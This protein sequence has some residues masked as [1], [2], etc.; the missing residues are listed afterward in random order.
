MIHP[1]PAY[2][3]VAPSCAPLPSPPSFIPAP[4][5]GVQRLTR[6]GEVLLD[7]AIRHLFYL[8]NRAP[9]PTEIHP[10]V[11]LWRCEQNLGAV[12]LRVS[13]YAVGNSA[14]ATASSSPTPGFA[15]REVC[16]V[17]V[18]IIYRAEPQFVEVSMGGLRTVA[19]PV[20]AQLADA[21][22]SELVRGLTFRSLCY[23]FNTLPELFSDEMNVAMR[24]A[25]EQ[26]DQIRIY[27]RFSLV[28]GPTMAAP[29]AMVSTVARIRRAC[30]MPVRATD[31]PFRKRRFEDRDDDEPDE[32][33]REEEEEA[34]PKPPPPK[35][36]RQSAVVLVIQMFRKNRLG[37]LLAQSRVPRSSAGG[38][39]AKKEK[40]YLRE[41]PIP[42]ILDTPSSAE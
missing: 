40:R 20:L 15:P 24:C 12:Q 11:R 34:R 39:Q 18:T 23:A 10:V 22:E 27:R 25:G 31:Q 2:D 19:I 36:K 7:R 1:R 32:W 26:P 41:T 29:D 30:A 28:S 21:R 38:F 9:L 13:W 35:K 33:E 42:Q 14:F 37:G 17:P 8:G 4:L 3:N 16:F 6:A 5:A